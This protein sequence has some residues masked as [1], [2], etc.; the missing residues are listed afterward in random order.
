MT[1]NEK[2]DVPLK[3][4]K[5]NSDTYL[6]VSVHVVQL[7]V[8]HIFNWAAQTIKQTK[9]KTIHSPQFQTKINI[10]SSVSDHMLNSVTVCPCVS[11][12][13]SCI[14]IWIWSFFVPQW[15]WPWTSDH[16]HP[17]G[18]VG[19]SERLNYLWLNP[20]KCCWD[21]MR[22]K[23]TRPDIKMCPATSWK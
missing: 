4:S 13:Y 1:S 19:S 12:L 6:C 20:L 3:V 7:Y 17:I 16:Q 8:T 21:I 23:R 11:E 2:N 10:S 5:E 14:W 18:T 9:N 22:I 15:G